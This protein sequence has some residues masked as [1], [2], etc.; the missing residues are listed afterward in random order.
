M[1][2][3]LFICSVAVIVC[4]IMAIIAF[5]P[6]IKTRL[7]SGNRITGHVELIING[8]NMSVNS[9]KIITPD[10]DKNSELKIEDG[11]FSI[12]GGEYGKYI[13]SFEVDD[14]TIR[15]AFNHDISLNTDLIKNIEFTYFSSNWWNIT[16][17]VLTIEINEKGN[18][19]VMDL[20]AEYCEQSDNYKKNPED[21]IEKSYS[22]S[23]A[24][25]SYECCFGL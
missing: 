25:Q 19:L 13:F 22:L 3:R 10:D 23:S 7:Y 20:K 8:V 18:E 11:A 9:S 14:E 4:L 17:M 5:F 12:K 2:R 16:D 6:F 21:K 1:R 15:K 24:E